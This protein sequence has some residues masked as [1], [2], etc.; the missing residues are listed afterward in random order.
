[1]KYFQFLADIGSRTT[2]LM[3]AEHLAE[4]FATGSFCPYG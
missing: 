4:A 3:P 1:M 2:V